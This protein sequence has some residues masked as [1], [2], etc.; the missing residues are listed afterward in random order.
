M[1]RIR[2]WKKDIVANIAQFL[3][4]RAHLEF[5]GRADR[6]LQR[7]GIPRIWISRDT[8]PLIIKVEEMQETMQDGNFRTDNEDG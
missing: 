3:F 7:E 5:F 4:K 8:V 1:I 2:Y 6:M